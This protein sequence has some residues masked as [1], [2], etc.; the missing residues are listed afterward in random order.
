MK[1]PVVLG[2]RIVEPG[3]LQ[4]AIKLG[5]E[6]QKMWDQA[7][8]E[9][10]KFN[11]AT[12]LDQWNLSLMCMHWDDVVGLTEQINQG[13]RYDFGSTGQMRRSPLVADRNEAAKEFTRISSQ[14]GLTLDSRTRLALAD[15]TT[16]SI[17][18]DL[19]ARLGVNPRRTNRQIESPKKK[20]IA[21]K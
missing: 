6:G 19:N 8:P 12:T 4:P 16:R 13:D 15:V 21:K 10:M 9:L 17:E 3:Q 18:S 11:A 2:Q 7:V 20:Q 5:P 1:R 14:Y